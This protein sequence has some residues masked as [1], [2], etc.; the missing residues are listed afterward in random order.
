MENIAFKNALGDTKR[1]MFSSS[2]AL[3]SSKL[4]NIGRMIDYIDFTDK[5]ISNA[6]AII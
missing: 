5:D 3:G 4:G 1:P 6:L 2:T